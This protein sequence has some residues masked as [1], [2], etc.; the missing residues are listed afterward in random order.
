MDRSRKEEHVVLCPVSPEASHI[1]AS[2]HS[3]DRQDLFS[4]ER[5]GWV[6]PVSTKRFLLMEEGGWNASNT[7]SR[8]E[9]RKLKH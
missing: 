2:T 8:N 5:V 3:H 4:I 7:P 1:L 9:F 6:L